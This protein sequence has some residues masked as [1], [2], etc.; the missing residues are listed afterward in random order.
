MKFRIALVAATVLAVPLAAT[1]QPINGLYV[2]AGAG[3]NIMQD[4]NVRVSALGRSAS[5]SAQ[6]NVGP[7]TDLSVGWGFGNGLR[8]EI[9]GDYRYNG[10]S[11]TSGFGSNTSAGGAERKWGVMGNVL[12]DFVGLSPFIQPYIGGGVGGQW[13]FDSGAH[14]FGPAGSGSLATPQA[15]GFAYQGI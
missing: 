5:G 12:Y 1:A 15:G 11:S 7:V 6:L 8:V 2:G 10:V 13:A 3:V 9:E 14:G 4:E